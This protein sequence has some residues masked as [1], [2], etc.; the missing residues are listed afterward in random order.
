MTNQRDDHDLWE[1]EPLKYNLC[2]P[3]KKRHWRPYDVEAMSGGGYAQCF[4]CGITISANFTVFG[5]PTADPFATPEHYCRYCAEEL[6][7]M[8]HDMGLKKKR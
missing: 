6:N 2:N 8:V 4:V 7:V 3:T 1:P 5:R